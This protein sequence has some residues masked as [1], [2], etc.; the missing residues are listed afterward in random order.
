MTDSSQFDSSLSQPPDSSL[1]GEP[2]LSHVQDV[3]ATVV[4]L[5][6]I[7]GILLLAKWKFLD[8]LPKWARAAVTVGGIV[9]C[10]LPPSIRGRALL[11]LLRLRTSAKE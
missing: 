9:I 7:A 1:S 2:R 10:G 11:A 6:C 5:A 4:S 3:C 8:D